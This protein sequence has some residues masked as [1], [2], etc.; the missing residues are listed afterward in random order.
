LLPILSA[1]GRNTNLFFQLSKFSTC[2][3]SSIKSELGIHT[4]RF[5]ELD[6]RLKFMALVMLVYEFMLQMWRNWKN[7]A[8][9]IINAWCPRADNRLL[10]NRLPIYRF[11]LALTHLLLFVLI[12]FSDRKKT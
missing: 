11:R 12:H 4:I 9:S 3:R 8:L 6:N 2:E 5:H 1:K 7:V 10:N